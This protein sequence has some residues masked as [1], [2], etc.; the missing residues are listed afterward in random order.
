MP[1]PDGNTLY[2]YFDVTNGAYWQTNEK[3]ERRKDVIDALLEK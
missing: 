3:G 1:L 2:T